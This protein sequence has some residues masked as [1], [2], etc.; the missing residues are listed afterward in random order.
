MLYAYTRPTGYI[1]STGY[2]RPTGYNTRPTR[3]GTGIDRNS[4]FDRN[5]NW[6]E[7]GPTK[8]KMSYKFIKHDIIS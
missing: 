4:N 3:C 1:R 6:P 5:R 7:F 2:T 8:Q